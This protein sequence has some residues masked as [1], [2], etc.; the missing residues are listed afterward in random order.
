M[1]RAA[2][3]GKSR[4]RVVNGA[5]AA[6]EAIVDEA[7]R[8]I[9]AV[10]LIRPNRRSPSYTVSHRSLRTSEIYGTPHAEGAEDAENR[11]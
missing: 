5:I 3:R 10:R 1:A 6:C 11:R 9:N 4:R 2:R 8:Q 7:R